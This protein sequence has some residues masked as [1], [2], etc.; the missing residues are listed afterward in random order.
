MINHIMEEYLK[1]V[2]EGDEA[3]RAGS[4]YDNPYREG[5]PAAMAWDD[6]WDGILQD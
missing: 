3:R 2:R 5:T 4:A 6:G 1:L